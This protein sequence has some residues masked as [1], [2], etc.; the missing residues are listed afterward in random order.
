MLLKKK[1]K[2]K[3]RFFFF[4]AYS[5]RIFSGWNVVESSSFCISLCSRIS[6]YSIPQD[7]ISKIDQYLEFIDLFFFGSRADQLHWTLF[8]TLLTPPVFVNIRKIFDFQE[9]NNFSLLD[10]E[11]GGKAYWIFI[12]LNLLLCVLS[13]KV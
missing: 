4:F 2:K 9:S 13:G 3:I 10:R 6:P 5:L 8:E 7:W 12:P 11:I 1:K